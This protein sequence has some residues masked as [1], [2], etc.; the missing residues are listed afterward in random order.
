[1]TYEKEFELFWEAVKKSVSENRFAKLTM[2]KT[3]GKPELKN[4]FVRPVYSDTEFKVLLKY[5]YLS[6]EKA[7][8]EKKLSIT[9]TLDVIQ[10]HLKNPFFTVILFTITEDITFKINKKGIGTI[11]TGLPTFTTI[12]PPK[13][14]D[15]E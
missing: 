6:R 12:I 13:S 4:I 11:S 8:I 2:A 15:E 7:D 5:R 1:M 9:E 14:D 10:N 3:I